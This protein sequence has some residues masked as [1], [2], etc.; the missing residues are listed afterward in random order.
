MFLRLLF[1]LVISIIAIET[2]RSQ[3]YIFNRFSTKDGLLTNNILSMVQDSSGYLWLGTENG[4]Q[5]YDGNFFR[6]ILNERIDQIISDSSHRIWIRS[7]KKLGIFNPTNFSLVNVI[8]EP[9]N[10]GGHE[11]A[12]NLRKDASGNVFIINEKGCQYFDDS[13]KSFSQKNNPF[14][15]PD[16]I[17][18][19]NVVEDKKRRRYWI[20]S[21]KGLGYWDS[22]TTSFYSA[23]NNLQKDP[24]LASK[25]LSKTI[26][27]FFIDASNRYWIESENNS[28]KNFFCYDAVKN[29]FTSD[30]TGLADAGNGS[31]F[32][33]KG[34]TQ[35]HDS[36][37]AVYGLNCL[38]INNGGSF[39]ELRDTRG[40][41]PYGIYFN[42][43]SA[44][45]EDREG[46]VWIA[47]DDG[48]YNTLGTLGRNIHAI[49]QM[50]KFR[51][52]VKSVI[53][54]SK[55]KL[56]IGTWGRGIFTITTNPGIYPQVAKPQQLQFSD[57]LSKLNWS[58]CEDKTSGRIWFGCELGRLMIYDTNSDKASL[59]HFTVFKDKHLKQIVEDRNGS[60][61]IGLSDGT[62]LQNTNPA[63]TP[64]DSS[65]QKVWAFEGG[66]SKLYF[67][68]ESQLWVAV[69]G[70]GI[71]LFDTQAG[72]ILRSFDGSNSDAQ[73]ITE[74]K[75]ILQLTDST[76]LLAAGQVGVL[77]VN[78]SIVEFSGT[79]DNLS[80]GNASTLQ[81][82]VNGNCW[83]G[84]SNGL[85]KYNPKTGS[86]T[87]YSQ[88]DGLI[89]VHNNSYIP[90]TS[91]R[92][93]DNRLVFAGNQHLL[94]FDPDDYR[95]MK[96]PPDVT[97]TGFQLNNRYLPADSL[98][99]LNRIRLPYTN[100]SFSIEFASISFSLL[101][102][103]TYEYKLEG[104]DAGWTTLKTVVPVKYNFLPP[105]NY[106]FL[107]RAKND[108]GQYSK[109]TTSI[110]I[111]IVPPFWRTP[112]FYLLMG[113]IIASVLFYLH[114]LRLERL[115]Q[116][117]KVR[118]RLARDLH[119]DMGSTLSTVNILSNIALQQTPLDEKTS[120]EYMSTINSST[121]Q[122]MEAMDDIVW[123][124]NPVNDSMAKV[125]ARMKEVA[126]SVL[127]PIHVEYRF[128]VDEDVMGVNF[129]MESRREIFLIFKEALNNIVKYAQC[130]NV[131]FTLK[132]DGGDFV[133][134]IKDDG[135]GF[136]A[137]ARTPSTRGNGLKNMRK[138]TE[139]LNGSISIDSEPG[140]GT[141]LRI[142]MPIA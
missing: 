121:G 58:I 51:S 49:F 140:K 63:G 88:Y 89:T 112:W 94:V 44:I 135:K 96:S 85:F 15:V 31:H 50:E 91:L 3:D 76:W 27:N 13:K 107:V 42:V 102:K 38:R 60:M 45:I 7:G 56:W 116:I 6:V 1:S 18:I 62:L 109:Q 141:R 111:R 104:V 24:L 28:T 4:L 34:F 125:L 86:L 9:G 67:I 66:I 41:N 128:Q 108:E 130:N 84:S 36:V 127:E 47:T 123:S 26:V 120:K 32:E 110:A 124:I 118:S 92:M 21:Q 30:T 100:S 54:D 82:D 61:W 48:L 132:K 113:A 105:G 69:E 133:L 55:Q 59:H 101:G 126:G 75:D 11:E 5:R 119:D 46:I 115:L 106:T 19:I 8:Y 12:P 35:Y 72:K 16:S 134:T 39:Q 90:E 129:S 43:V 136:D 77:N 53:E 29:Q 83:I 65:F 37:I 117:E 40:H 23:G 137:E 52:F 74:V 10:T 14:I 131:L 87:K 2:A 70:K 95:V 68:N 33:V 103:L 25:L 80:I 138:R 139:N 17:S 73:W 79:I 114:R 98:Q 122:M 78:S 71:F 81:R 22:K 93:D 64:S 142:A 20:I 99:Q 97:I 57:S